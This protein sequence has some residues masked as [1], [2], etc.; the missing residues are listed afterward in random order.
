[1]SLVSYLEKYYNSCI[2]QN[3]LPFP[4]PVFPVP[5]PDTVIKLP[6]NVPVPE[7]CASVKT[8]TLRYLIIALKQYEYGFYN[9]VLNSDRP[10]FLITSYYSLYLRFLEVLYSELEVLEQ[11]APDRDTDIIKTVNF[12]V[13]YFGIPIL[14]Y[15]TRKEVP[16]NVSD[17]A[18]VLLHVLISTGKRKS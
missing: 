4:D 16:P 2:P 10:D 11:S 7:T 13:G 14:R 15:L 17:L 8:D 1:M 5:D 18:G 12:V 3:G 9:T 6:Q